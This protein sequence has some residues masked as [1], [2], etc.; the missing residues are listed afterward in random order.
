MLPAII[1]VASV[2]VL[3]LFIQYF[4]KIRFTYGKENTTNVYAIGPKK[5]I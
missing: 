3:V 4:V 5:H 2:I 1:T